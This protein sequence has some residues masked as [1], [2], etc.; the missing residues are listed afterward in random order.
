MFCYISTNKLKQGFFFFF[1]GESSSVRA[2]NIERNMSVSSG[3]T[4]KDFHQ[5]NGLNGFVFKIHLGA[6]DESKLSSWFSWP[7]PSLNLGKSAKP[8]WALGSL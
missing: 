5:G 4:L 2:K 7:L 1:F 6:V 8:L 3:K